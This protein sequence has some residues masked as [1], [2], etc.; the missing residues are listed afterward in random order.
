MGRLNEECYDI[1]SVNC[2]RQRRYDLAGVCTCMFLSLFFLC[3]SASR[4]LVSAS[5][6]QSRN[7]RSIV[8]HYL[9]IGLS[10][11]VLLL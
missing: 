11:F 3:L 6:G 10:T 4:S 9:C 1:L 5:I 7:H 8:Q 2:Q